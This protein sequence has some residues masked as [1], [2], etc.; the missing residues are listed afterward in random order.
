MHIRTNHQYRNTLDWCQLTT[1][2]QRE[3][4]YLDTDDARSRAEFV[5]YKGWIYDVSEFL[6]ICPPIA[7]HAQRPGW[8]HWDAYY[9]NSFFSGILLAYNGDGQV[10]LATFT[11]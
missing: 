6:A 3:F 5:R 10:K 8:E 7:P 2:E 11:C 1:K 4:D 9:S